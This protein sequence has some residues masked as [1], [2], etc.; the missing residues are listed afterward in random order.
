[1]SPGEE[2][3]GQKEEG[4]KIA[5][6]TVPIRPARLSGGSLGGDHSL[7]FQPLQEQ[8]DVLGR[9]PQGLGY[10]IGTAGFA[11]EEV[12]KDLAPEAEIKQRLVAEGR[13][14]PLD[15]LCNRAGGRTASSLQDNEGRG[16]VADQQGLDPIE[17]SAEMGERP[18][19]QCEG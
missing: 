11:R 5:V 2:L 10:F 16:T 14:Q 19:S 9:M 17:A 7:F 13:V 8:E 12:K 1:M 4:S 15:F 18:R 3:A 6:Q